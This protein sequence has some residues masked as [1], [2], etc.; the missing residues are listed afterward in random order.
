M[1]IYYRSEYQLNEIS[2]MNS[3]TMKQLTLKEMA[4]KWKHCISDTVYVSLITPN[5][6][7]FI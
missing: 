6:K 7:R 4:E 3:I 1:N 5:S 2:I